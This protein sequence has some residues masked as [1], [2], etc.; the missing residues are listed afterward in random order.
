[1]SEVVL[2]GA[3][4][5]R[6]F[7]SGSDVLHVLA[8]ADLRISAGEI[9]AVVGP[10]GSGKSTLLHCL[11][12]LD[13]PDGGT[14]RLGGQDL[15]ALG[16]EERSRVR[17]R[18][19]GFVFQFHHL[20]PDFSAL[21][22]VLL[23]RLI[24][25]AS[26]TEAE[27]AARRMLDAVGLADRASHAPSELS[28]GEQQR[29]AVARALVNEPDVVLADEPSGNLDVAT[30]RSLHALIGRLREERG[31]TFLLA[32][33]DPALAASADRV[34]AMDGGRLVE[35]DPADPETWLRKGE[36]TP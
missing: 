32:T 7:A 35:A 4:L 24:A 31:A 11:G 33:H 3:G 27:G 16:E 10:S 12:G 23:P 20:L 25:G 22:N 19:I 26:R 8:G 28:G 30:S 2:E 6:N 15:A 36:V 17:N 21:E 9:V 13:R 14:V 18:R 1:M 34:L 29:V 5:V